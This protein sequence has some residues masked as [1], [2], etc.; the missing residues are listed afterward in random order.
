MKSMFDKLNLRP[1]ERR[2]VVGVGILIFV[3]LNLTF[4]WPNFG[5][6]AGTQKTIRETE[7][8]LRRFKME[9]NRKA[10]YERELR[11]LED[12]GVFVG[13]EVQELELQREVRSQ[14]QIAGVDVRGYNPSARGTSARTNA[15]FDETS[16]VINFVSGEKELVD[17]LYR[18]GSGNSLIRVRDMNLG[19]EL[20]ARQKLQGSLTL[21]ES[22]Q[23]K[24]VK[25]A[26]APP[27]PKKTAP[28][29][30]PPKAADKTKPAP[31]RQPPSNT[32]TNPVRK[33]GQPGK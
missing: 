21:V 20:P 6:Y 4:V 33:A 32:K 27:P 30:A 3:V 7:N 23:K 22:F 26:A 13:E 25:V 9:V 12:K 18:L 2:L 19:T 28:A 29:K 11:T 8:K 15:F 17:F 16:L 14:A 5:A 24:P 1:G 10:G 31:A